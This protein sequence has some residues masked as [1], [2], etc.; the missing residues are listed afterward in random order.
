MAGRDGY[1]IPVYSSR[2]RLYHWLTACLI[3]VQFPIGFYMTYRGYEMPWTNEAGEAK[4]GLFDGV[5]GTLYDTHKLI[6]L[7][8]LAVVLARLV[9]RLK[10]GAP[11]SDPSVP[12]ALTGIAHGVHWLIY[13]LLIAVPIGG[14][15]GVSYYGALNVFG[16][17]LVAVTAK[18]EKF[19]ETIFEAHEAAALTLLA[20]IVLHVGAA[21][22]HRVVRKDRVV[23]RMLPKKIV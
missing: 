17:P 9:Y 13:V 11:S 8:I 6:G 16:L 2:A 5:T 14:Y 22:Y 3:L 7:T 15:I 20:L 21:V 4:T 18:D 10:N 12:P 19:S 1:D 23:E